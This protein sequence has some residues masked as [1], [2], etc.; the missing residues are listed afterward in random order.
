VVSLQL[1]SASQAASPV[2]SQLPLVVCP[3][4]HSVVSR[5][6]HRPR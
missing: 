2:P 1:R 4:R 6:F 5:G 3:Q